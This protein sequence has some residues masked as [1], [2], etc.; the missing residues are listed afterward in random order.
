M[1]VRTPL[2][3][4]L[5]NTVRIETHDRGNNP[6]GVGTSFILSHNFQGHGDELFLVSNKHVIKDGFFAYMYF[7]ELRD[8]KPNIGKPFFIKSDFFSVGWIGHPS[9][10]VDL[11]IMPLSWELDMIEK[12]KGGGTKAFYQKVS[13]EII[14]TESEINDFDAMEPI[15]FI[16]YPNG[17]FD[18]K[19]Y[20]PI[21]RRGT[22]ATPI[23]LDY[24]GSPT[25]LIDASV[26]PGSSGS[27]VFLYKQP[28]H[29]PSDSSFVDKAYIRLLGI[30]SAV[31]FRTQLGTL[32]MVPAPVSIAPTVEIKEMI[33]LG[34][35]F[36]S[37]L[38]L[39]LINIFWGEN[40]EKCREW[41]RAWE[42]KKP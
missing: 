31:F 7:T 21:V 13:T 8:G 26:F 42:H 17:I 16:G 22:T 9:S 28:L 5:F 1:E 19:H 6:I 14:P 24:D 32:E 3:H 12:G 20:T 34:V 38:I 40:E 10:E 23:Q 29:S 4:L 25:F 36:K 18:R 15:I 37:H 33:D 30:L 41:K 27:P 11:A 39:D 35:V 2:Q